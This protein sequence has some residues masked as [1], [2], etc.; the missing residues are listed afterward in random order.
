LAKKK[1]RK[2]KTK[3]EKKLKEKHRRQRGRLLAKLASPFW[4][5]F[6]G[7]SYHTN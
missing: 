7:N 2:N 3:N 5:V 1:T 6:N 4:L